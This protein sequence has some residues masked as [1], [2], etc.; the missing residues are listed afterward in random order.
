MTDPAFCRRIRTPML[1]VV[2][3]ADRV[4]SV[5][6]MERFTQRLKTATLVRI[7]YARHEILMERNSLR[8]Q[9]WAAFGVF[10]PG[11]PVSLRLRHQQL[12]S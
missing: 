10:I 1:V 9:F 5:G 11:D 4:V 12:Q 6:A 7:P 8:E 3:G 2:P